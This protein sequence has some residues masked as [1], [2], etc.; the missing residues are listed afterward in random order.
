M[1]KELKIKDIGGLGKLCPLCKK[2][3]IIYVKFRPA[4]LTSGEAEII[5]CS[6]EKC[7]AHIKV[8]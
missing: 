6:N 7:S 3:V 2:G 1:S 8:K 5:C 4:G